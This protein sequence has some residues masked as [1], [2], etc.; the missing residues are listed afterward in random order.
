M[1][2]NMITSSTWGEEHVLLKALLYLGYWLVLSS[3][4]SVQKWST[5]LAVYQREERIVYPVIDGHRFG[6]IPGV[7]HT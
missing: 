2:L 5:G 4:N 7:K 6:E 1:Q 3:D